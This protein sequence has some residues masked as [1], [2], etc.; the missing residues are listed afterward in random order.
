MEELQELL[1]AIKEGT[2]ATQSAVSKLERLIK[3]MNTKEVKTAV[4]EPVVGESAEA[5]KE[6]K[7]EEENVDLKMPNFEEEIPL[8]PILPA[9]DDLNLSQEELPVEETSEETTEEESVEHSEMNEE[10]KLMA[11]KETHELDENLVDGTLEQSQSYSNEE[12][13][14]ELSKPEMSISE[15]I[16]SDISQG[17]IIQPSQVAFQEQVKQDER[18]VIT[19]FSESPANIGNIKG[20]FNSE[21][22]NSM[23]DST[24]K[25]PSLE[26]N[27]SELVNEKPMVTN[28]EPEVKLPLQSEDVQEPKIEN[29]QKSASEESQNLVNPVQ[30]SVNP[31]AVAQNLANNFGDKKRMRTV[32]EMLAEMEQKF[33]EEGKGR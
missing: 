16:P 8:S 32:D 22:I 4:E 23:I 9:L 28:E 17:E 20:Y 5:I 33:N 12:E 29:S 30:E 10:P 7:Q 15:E 26:K 25:T 14:V 3:N 18:L 31:E 24:N 2:S 6:E 27:N 13:P 11:S 21:K 1:N 19:R